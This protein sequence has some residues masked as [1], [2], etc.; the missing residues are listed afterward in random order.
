MTFHVII[1]ARMAS[2]RLPNKPLA[3]IGG[4]PMVVRVA[5]QATKSGAASVTVAGDDAKIIDAAKA[6][7]FSALMTDAH[8]TSGTER[9]HQAAMLLNLDDDAIV[10]NVQGDEP[11]IPPRLIARVASELAQQKHAVMATACHAIHDSADMLN[12]NIVKVV[13]NADSLA[14]YF[15][16]APIPYPRDAFT[17]HDVDKLPEGLPVFRHIG[18]YAYR[19]GFLKIYS[20]LSPTAMEKFESLEQLRVLW[21]GY[22]IAVS[23]ETDAPPAGVDTPQD[24]A[25]V[26]KIFRQ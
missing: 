13:L 17:Q 6:A 7:G 19:V 20:D 18:I 9:I 26:Q 15:S 5:Q 10:V 22:K 1:P 14:M 23:V 24:L 8:H 3:D 12:P 16:R 4:A 11:L 21:H 25:R 2:M